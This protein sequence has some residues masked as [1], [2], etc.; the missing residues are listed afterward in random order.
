MTYLVY[1]KGFT[2]LLDVVELTNES[3]IIFEKENKGKVL[4]KAEEMN[5]T[6]EE[7]DVFDNEDDEGD[8]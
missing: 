4:V 8:E 3:K 5:S 1:D 6:L 2:E 7:F